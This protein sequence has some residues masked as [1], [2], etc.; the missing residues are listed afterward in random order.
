MKTAWIYHCSPKL[1]PFFSTG[2]VRIARVGA[3]RLRPGPLQE[4]P[5]RRARELA[6]PGPRRHD[7]KPD[8]RIHVHLYLCYFTFRIRKQTS[9]S[10]AGASAKD[11]LHWSFL[12]IT[13]RKIVWFQSPEMINRPN[14]LIEEHLVNAWLFHIENNKNNKN[15]RSRCTT[16]MILRSRT[17]STR[18][19]SR[20]PTS[21]WRCLWVQ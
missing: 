21:A 9:T 13:M 16:T 15:N 14:H 12:G 20:R 5:L 4:P 3:A 18:S 17:D 11:D 8:Y 2:F 6:R 19:E 10:K 1:R 7:G